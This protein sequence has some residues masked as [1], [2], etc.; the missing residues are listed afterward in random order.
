[1]PAQLNNIPFSWLKLKIS[2]H[3]FVDSDSLFVPDLCSFFCRNCGSTSNTTMRIKTRNRTP[4]RLSKA[5]VQMCVSHSVHPFLPGLH[6]LSQAVVNLD[7]V[8]CDHA[9]AG[10]GYRGELSE[11]D[12]LSRPPWRWSIGSLSPSH[13]PHSCCFMS[14]LRSSLLWLYM[15]KLNVLM[16]YSFCV[17]LWSNYVQLSH[18]RLNLL[19][20]FF[21]SLFIHLVVASSAW[22][23][24]KK[25]G[26]Y[27]VVLLLSVLKCS[28]LWHLEVTC[29][30]KRQLSFS[31]IHLPTVWD[32]K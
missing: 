7:F 9:Q 23:C 10:I 21:F 13:T 12:W 2:T 15:N 28:R 27:S 14:S 22:V 18:P 16:T 32:W 6:H 30:L 31:F 26:I 24:Q 4:L 3:S 20:M 29:S 5:T 11:P 1:M 17:L 25:V 8:L 19:V